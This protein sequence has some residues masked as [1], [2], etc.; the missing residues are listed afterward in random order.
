MGLSAG[1]IKSFWLIGTNAWACQYGKFNNKKL[2]GFKDSE[3]ED[4]FFRIK[5]MLDVIC[6]FDPDAENNCLTLSEIEAI[7][8]KIKSEL[9]FTF[10]LCELPES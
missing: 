10:A 3:L 4:N 9:C 1:Q 2:K 6:N 7:M 5:L 8:E